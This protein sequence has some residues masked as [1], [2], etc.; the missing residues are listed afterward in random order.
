M[1][2]KG[3]PGEPKLF[4]IKAMNLKFIFSQFGV[5]LWTLLGFILEPFGI[6]F[7]SQATETIALCTDALG[8]LGPL[9][10]LFGGILVV[11]GTIRALPGVQTLLHPF[12]V[13]GI[14]AYDE[15]E[16]FG[17]LIIQDLGAL[18]APSVATRIPSWITVCVFRQQ[19]WSLLRASA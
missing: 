16:E 11:S 8:P 13:G 6:T 7:G 19:P 3:S 14:N 15:L 2:Q 18:W 10:I 12:R 5:P 9:Q 17:N 1:A 4:K